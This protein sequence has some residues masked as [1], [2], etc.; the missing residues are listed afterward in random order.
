MAHSTNVDNT[1]ACFCYVQ[2]SYWRI[3]SSFPPAEL[4]RIIAAFDEKPSAEEEAT[5]AVDSVERSDDEVSSD[6]ES[7]ANSDNDGDDDDV[8]KSETEQEDY[9]RES[10]TEQE[11]ERMDDMDER[12]LLKRNRM[13]ALAAL[14]KKRQEAA[15]ANNEERLVALDCL[16]QRFLRKFFPCILYF[17][18]RVKGFI[19]G[20]RCWHI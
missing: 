9:V 4:R 10:E 16:V 2:E 12:A 11:P 1:L 5:P 3:D 7:S 8:R 15:A 14:A 19:T 6:S 20:R 17:F 18:Q 13:A